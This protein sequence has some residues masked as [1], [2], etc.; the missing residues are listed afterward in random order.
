MDQ[1]R[2]SGLTPAAAA[3]AVG[4][5]LLLSGL[6]SGRYSPDPT[7]PRLRR[8]YKALDKPSVTPPDAVFGG[9]W[10]ILLTGLGVGT[11]RLLRQPESVSRNGAVL[12]AATTLGLVTGYSK[13]TFGDRDLTGGA[14]ESK[15]L[16]GAAAAYVA[17]ASRTDSRAALLGLPLLLWSCFGSWLTTELRVRNPALDSGA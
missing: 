16:I 12:L 9:A 15:V 8:W 3:F 7:H 11:Y 6:I 17:A 10:P 2:Y 4:G 14:T 13:V 5:A 1:N